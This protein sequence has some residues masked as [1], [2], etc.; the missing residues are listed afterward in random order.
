M[1]THLRNQLGMV[2]DSYIG[3]HPGQSTALGVPVRGFGAADPQPGVPVD[4]VEGVTMFGSTEQAVTQHGG[5]M[6]HPHMQIMTSSY[7]DHPN[8][9]LS[10]QVRQVLNN[11]CTS[12]VHVVPVGRSSELSPKS[13]A[14]TNLIVTQRALRSW[15]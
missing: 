10:Q 11:E 5:S 2:I 12:R 6:A 8:A 9:V 1:N 7:A 3:P 14:H 13:V 15:R 4:S